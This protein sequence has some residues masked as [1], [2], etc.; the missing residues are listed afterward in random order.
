MSGGMGALGVDSLS[1]DAVSPATL[2]AG[3]FGHGAYGFSFG[4]AE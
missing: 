3:T 4:G 2:Y 1:Y